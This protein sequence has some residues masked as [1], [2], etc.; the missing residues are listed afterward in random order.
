[1]SKID[2]E[3]AVIRAENDG[4]FEIKKDRDYYL[5]ISRKEAVLV[6]SIFAMGYSNDKIYL[7]QFGFPTEH[8]PIYDCWRDIIGDKVAMKHEREQIIKRLSHDHEYLSR[9]AK[10]CEN[11]GNVIFEESIK[12]KEKS[13]SESTDNELKEL[14]SRL[15]TSMVNYSSYL[16]FPL[17]LQSYLEEKLREMIKE[18]T[19]ST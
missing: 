10:N 12:L 2:F 19:E 8:K 13:F 7:K 15:L 4:P 5:L 1:M 9:I 3:K 14:V 6:L 16:L 17:S 11:E 18:R